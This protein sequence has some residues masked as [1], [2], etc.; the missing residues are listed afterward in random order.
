MKTRKVRTFSANDREVQM[1]EAI[2]Q[3]HGWNKSRMI[4]GLIRKEFWRIFPG[5]KDKIHP[6]KGARIEER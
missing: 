3:Y 4:T 5:G 1:L 2:A 6:T